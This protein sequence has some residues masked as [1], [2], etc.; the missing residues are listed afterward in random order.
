MNL[1]SSRFTKLRDTPGWL[2]SHGTR[3]SW[4]FDRHGGLIKT[5]VARRKADVGAWQESS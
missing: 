5:K 4:Y 1:S 3:L 2:L